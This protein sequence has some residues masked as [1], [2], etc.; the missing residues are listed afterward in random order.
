MV[1]MC[2]LSFA[3]SRGSCCTQVVDVN[4]YGQPYCLRVVMVMFT[5]VCFHP[6]VL[7]HRWIRSGL[8]SFFVDSEFGILN[9]IS[10]QRGI[11]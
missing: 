7:F 2:Y 4:W 9:K 11:V 5:V 1:P 8:M 3:A 6:S 10:A